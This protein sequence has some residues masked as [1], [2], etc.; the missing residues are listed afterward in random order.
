M[1]FSVFVWFVF[2]FFLQEQDRFAKPTT[3]TEIWEISA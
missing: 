1:S 2:T 3:I